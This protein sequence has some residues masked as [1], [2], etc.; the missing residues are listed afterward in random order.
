V[1]NDSPE[2]SLAPGRRRRRSV[3]DE[4]RKTVIDTAADLIY[5]RGY[6]ATSINDISNAVGI[7]KGSLYYYIRSKDDLLYEIVLD[8]HSYTHQNLAICE[9]LPTTPLGKIRAYINRHIRINTDN[10]AK[11]TIVY[12]DLMYLNEERRA[13]IVAGRDK[14]ETW[15]RDQIRAGQDAGEMCP[16]IDPKMATIAMFSMANA[17]YQWYHLDGKLTPAEVAQSHTDF[18]VAGLA[19]D[20]ATHTPGHRSRL[21]AEPTI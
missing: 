13:E 6:D 7:V 14:V 16:D 9:K 11:S 1:Q 15:V 12:R 8:A 10:L 2:L 18:L 17:I 21:A 20:P 4:R 3:N 19:C 5:R